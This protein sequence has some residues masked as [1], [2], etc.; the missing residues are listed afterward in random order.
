L[1]SLILT[2]H[3]NEQHWIPT[4]YSKESSED[5]KVNLTNEEE[6]LMNTLFGGEEDEDE[7]GSGR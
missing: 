7:R 3:K 1:V 2:K 5:K 6:V 4:A